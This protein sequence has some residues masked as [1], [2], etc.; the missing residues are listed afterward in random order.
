[1]SLTLSDLRQS[2]PDAVAMNTAD[3]WPSANASGEAP[4]AS[5]AA[6]AAS[7]PEP[8]AQRSGVPASV[9]ASKAAPAAIRASM[10][11]ALPAVPPGR[12]GFRHSGYWKGVRAQSSRAVQCDALPSLSGHC[13]YVLG[14]M[15]QC[16]LS[17]SVL[18]HC[19]EDCP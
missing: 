6:T 9:G 18:L 19:N 15:S 14:M 7:A 17:V 2:A 16:T 1:M 5:R 8:A 12:S 4:A 13:L 3:T 11:A 10:T